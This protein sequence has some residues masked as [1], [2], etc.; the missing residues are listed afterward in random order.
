MRCKGMSLLDFMIAL[1]IITVLLSAGLPSLQN[2]L[3]NQRMSAAASQLT[4]HI[5]LARNAA[6]TRSASVV[7]CPSQDQLICTD[8]NRWQSGWLLFSDDNGNRQHETA[9]AI[10]Q[11]TGALP[12]AAHS[13]GRTRIRFRA[14]GT[15]LGTNGS[16]RLCDDRGPRYGYRLILSNVGRLRREGPGIDQC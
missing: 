9:E 16:I 8:D 7:L 3:K 4:S 11:V 12:V 13:A 14:D 6:I 1:A 5:N 2:L 15:A 10:I